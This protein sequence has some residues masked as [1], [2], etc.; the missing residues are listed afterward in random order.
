M[1]LKTVVGTGQLERMLTK[2]I[3]S[4]D[5]QEWTATHCKFTG[6][7]PSGHHHHQFSAFR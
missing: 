1:G 6:R 7:L 5:V 4:V 3:D 2:S